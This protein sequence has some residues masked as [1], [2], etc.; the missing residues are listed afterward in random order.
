MSYLFYLKKHL[1]LLSALLISLSWVLIMR[2]HA[3]HHGH[4]LP[5]HMFL[6]YFYTIL[7]FFTYTQGIKQKQK[8]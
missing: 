4:F 5:R 2:D 3:H 6:V 7:V 8:I 1:C